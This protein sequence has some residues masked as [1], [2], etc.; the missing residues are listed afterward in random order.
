MPDLIF[1]SWSGGKDCCAALDKFLTENSTAT[2]SLLTM[3]D[4]S[5]HK[6]Y[7]HFLSEKILHAQAAAMNLEINF[8]YAGFHDYEQK[9]TAEL[10]KLKDRGFTAGI[11]G[12]IDLEE[13]YV[14]IERVMKKVGM[15][16]IM[17]LWQQNRDKIVLDFINRKY[18]SKIISINKTKIDTKYLGCEINIDT[19]NEFKDNGIDPSGEGGEFH[20]IVYGGPLFMTPLKLNLNTVIDERDHVFYDL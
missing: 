11:F 9:W 3:I 15:Q 10:L 6:T 19:F 12:D 13:H 1:C 8:G 5:N 20:T 14:W 2:I 17:P 18:S 7:G 16:M 4:E